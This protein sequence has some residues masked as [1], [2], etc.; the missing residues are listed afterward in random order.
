MNGISVVTNMSSLQGYPH[1]FY[2]LFVAIFPISTQQNKFKNVLSKHENLCV[3]SVEIHSLKKILRNQCLFYINKRIYYS[4]FHTK[5]DKKFH[6]I[7]K[8]QFGSKT[9]VPR[10]LTPLRNETRLMR[11]S[12]NKKKINETLLVTK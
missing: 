6:A 8:Y 1:L 5:N 2:F 3:C 4:S 7:L 12:K 11:I 10:R 9:H